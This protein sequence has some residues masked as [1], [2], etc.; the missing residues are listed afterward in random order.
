MSTTGFDTRFEAVGVKYIEGRLV[1][2]YAGRLPAE[3]VDRV[4]AEVDRRYAGA[5]V[6]A[7]VP[8]L[9][10]REARRVLDQLTE[11]S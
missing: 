9:V 4:V 5:S 8:L 2:R 1:A 3:T 10:E 6:H 7:F 11:Q